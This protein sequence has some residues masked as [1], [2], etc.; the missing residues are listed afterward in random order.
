[1]RLNLLLVSICFVGALA[2]CGR[3]PEP[4]LPP[5]PVVAPPAKATAAA[6]TDVEPAHPSLRIATLDGSAFDLAAHRGRWVVVNFWATWCAPCIKEMPDL[7]ALDR[8]REDLE[9]IGLAY[10]DITPE[11]MRAF[12]Q[13]RPV[14]YPI[15]IVDVADP[16]PAFDTPRGLPMTHLIAPDGRLAKSFL[17]PVT[18]AEIDAAI[19]AAGKPS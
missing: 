2:A 4:T 3:E 10:E 13:R 11:D 19:A 14:D 8:R 9:V 16:P 1:M 18:G 17:G 6:V 15:A 5:T 12:L 7:D